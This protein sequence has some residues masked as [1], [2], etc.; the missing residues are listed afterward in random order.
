MK[1]Y[2]KNNLPMGKWNIYQRKKDALAIKMK[3]PFELENQ[4]CE[5]GY[6]VIDANHSEYPLYLTDKA[7]K[8]TYKPAEA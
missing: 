4:F 5:D 8:S 1:A 3:G 2:H 6:I 7:F